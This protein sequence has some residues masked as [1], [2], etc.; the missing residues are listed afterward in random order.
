M[1]EFDA[2]L[3]L[4]KTGFDGTSVDGAAF[5]VWLS[6]RA[7]DGG[8]LCRVED[9]ILLPASQTASDRIGSELGLR[10]DLTDAVKD[11]EV[12]EPTTKRRG[13]R[14]ADCVR[15][16]RQDGMWMAQSQAPQRKAV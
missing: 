12:Q 10:G 4:Q 5:G 1:E 9:N 14:R 7:E 11:G 6:H 3:C 15:R 2:D 13:S 8:R 16:G